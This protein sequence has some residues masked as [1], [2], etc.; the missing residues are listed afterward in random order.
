MAPLEQLGPYIQDALDLIEFANGPASSPW[1][2]KLAEMGH[3]QPFNLKM[4]RW[5]NESAGPQYIERYER[6]AKVL[7]AKHP[8]IKL[9][10]GAG[11]DPAGDNFKLAWE[12]LGKLKADIVDE[13]AHQQPEWFFNNAS[14]Y[15]KY[16]RKG[17][18]VMMGEY[19]AHSEPGL[20]SPNNRGN[21]KC[22]LSEAAFFTGLE[23][24]ADIVI[25]SCYAPLFAHVDAWQWTPDLV[26]FDNLSVYGT[27]SYYVQQMFSRNR[28]EVV[29][30]VVIQ[31]PEESGG[32]KGGAIGLGT[33]ATQ[34]EF[35]DIKV[36]HGGQTLF[37]CN[38][39]NETKGWK[40]LG[41]GNWKAEKGVLSQ[42]STAENV[43]AIVSDK[44]WSD[45][46]YSLKARKLGGAEGF[47]ILFNVQDENA[48]SWWNI[49]GFGNTRHCIEMNGIISQVPGSIETGAG[50]TS[51]SNARAKR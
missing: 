9:I 46:T 11:P 50:I 38:F 10:A 14:R 31:A 13:H 5:G 41:E 47:L 19:A 12:K 35:K 45:C 4:I 2:K 28:G 22:A 32:Q 20:E 51:K 25:M 16:D 44:L 37:S 24:N 48:K 21:L 3:P 30:P 6:F 40:L 8:E 36:V 34:A 7:K 17:P 1:G 27:P 42:N 39:A 18:K 26:W 15:D 49:G 29:L 43:R 33:W 23:C